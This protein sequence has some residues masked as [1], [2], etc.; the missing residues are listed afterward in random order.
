MEIEICTNMHNTLLCGK[1]KSYTRWFS[2]VSLIFM[3]L[4]FSLNVHSTSVGSES[5]VD[6]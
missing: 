6:K 1:T 2:L 4:A 5:Y 3:L